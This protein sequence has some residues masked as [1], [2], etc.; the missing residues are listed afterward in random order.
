MTSATLFALDSR[1]SGK[2]ILAD[3]LDNSFHLI[4]G[5]L[6]LL[7]EPNCA[8]KIQGVKAIKNKNRIENL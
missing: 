1:P 8:N 4:P 2:I 7:A 5:G 3:L 6:P